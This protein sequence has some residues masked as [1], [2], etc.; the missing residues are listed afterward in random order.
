MGL[1]MKTIRVAPNEVQVDEIIY[2]FTDSGVADVFETCISTTGDVYHC[3][4]DQMAMQRR[5]ADPGKLMSDIEPHR[6]PEPYDRNQA[7]NYGRK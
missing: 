3:T 1:A 2:T 7:H 5:P 4:K 6:P